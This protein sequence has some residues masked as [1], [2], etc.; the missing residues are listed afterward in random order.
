MPIPNCRICGRKDF[1]NWQEVATHINTATDKAHKQDKAGIKWAAN[2]KFQ[3][4]FYKKQEQERITNTPEQLEAKRD[5]KY[6]LSGQTEFVSVICPNVKCSNH[7]IPGRIALP[8]EHTH[9]PDALKEN[10]HYV[11]FCGVC[12]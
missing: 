8:V 10:G 3:K 11:K 1:E 2:F 9:N 12:K 7:R 6:E 5:A 4:V